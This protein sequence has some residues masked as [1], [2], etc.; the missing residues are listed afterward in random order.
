ME[1]INIGAELNPIYGRIGSAAHIY[2]YS[3]NKTQERINTMLLN[4]MY[5]FDLG[6][7]ITSIISGADGKTNIAEYKGGTVTAS[8]SWNIT[9]KHDFKFILDNITCPDGIYLD[10]DNTFESTMTELTSE[11]MW[12]ITGKTELKAGKGVTTATM[13]LDMEEGF[14]VEQ[15]ASFYH[16]PPIYYGFSDLE[17]VTN[18]ALVFEE[19]K[20]VSMTPSGR[21]KM[22]NETG[23]P[24]YFYICIPHTINVSE[25]EV[26]SSGFQVPFVKVLSEN[27]SNT[28]LD[29]YDCWR[30]PTGSMILNSSEIIYDVK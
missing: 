3:N 27:T 28:G 22:I 2:D 23:S 7:N 19:S 8:I 11:Q 30:N 16:L 21:Y 26:F 25:I 14:S 17:E 20:L 5:S 9:R 12:S 24:A 6:L 1:K 13:G 29:N 4:E 15:Q 10:I 18:P